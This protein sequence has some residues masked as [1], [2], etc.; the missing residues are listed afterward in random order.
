MQSI[1]SKHTF[2]R[3]AACFKISLF[4]SSALLEWK[5]L[6]WLWMINTI[7]FNSVNQKIRR[8]KDKRSYFHFC[9]RLVRTRRRG[10][11]P[12]TQQAISLLIQAFNEIVKRYNLT[13]KK[14]PKQS[15][16]GLTYKKHDVNSRSAA[17]KKLMPAVNSSHIHE[18]AFF[19]NT[20]AFLITRVKKC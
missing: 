2:P 18:V 10:T 3:S 19:S 5:E 12:I 15:F 14:I 20:L 17:T 8:F 4:R 7:S 13:N 6:L 1:L 9:S 16:Q 11:G